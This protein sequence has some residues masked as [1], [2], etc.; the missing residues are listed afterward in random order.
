MSRSL[1]GRR[2]PRG[3]RVLVLREDRDGLVTGRTPVAGAPPARSPAGGTARR[4]PG[5]SLSWA[6]PTCSWRASGTPGRRG[7][8]AAAASDPRG[9]CPTRS[10][11][12]AG[13]SPAA[14]RPARR[15]AVR[16]VDRRASRRG[17]ART[18]LGGRA[19]R[20]APPASTPRAVRALA[21]GRR[22][23]A[24]AGGRR[25]RPGRRCAPPVPVA[26]GLRGPVTRTGDWSCPRT[27]PPSPMAAR[28]RQTFRSTVTT[29]PR[30][31]ASSPGIGAYAGLCGSSHTCPSVRL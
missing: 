15:G 3:R 11:S 2:F 9:R 5:R 1:E 24:A 13:C 31:T 4:C 8:P 22:R 27:C 12:T 25:R 30:T 21:R 28:A 26:E 17:P 14:Q 20:W 6:A 29:R 7:R 16:P 18:H 19:G 23:A 10:R